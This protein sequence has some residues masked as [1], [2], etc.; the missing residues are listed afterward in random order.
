MSHR[1]LTSLCAFFTFQQRTAHGQYCELHNII[2]PLI[3]FDGD[4]VGCPYAKDPNSSRAG[5]GGPDAGTKFK[6]C[7]GQTY[8]RN[9]SGSIPDEVGQPHQKITNAPGTLSM[10]NTGAPESGGSQFFINVNDN[11]FLDWFDKSTES[12]H[13]VFGKVSA[14]YLSLPCWMLTILSSYLIFCD[15][16]HRSLKGMIL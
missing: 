7:D 16:F 15:Y 6:S 10:A 4:A 12:A 14:F 11:S 2:T 1:E 8:S 13:P 3:W 9:R 5:T